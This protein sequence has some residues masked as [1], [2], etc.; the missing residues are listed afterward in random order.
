[1]QSGEPFVR[2]RSEGWTPAEMPRTLRLDVEREWGG[3]M[4]EV[5]RREA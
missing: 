4:M 2:P 5:V 1:M 3:G